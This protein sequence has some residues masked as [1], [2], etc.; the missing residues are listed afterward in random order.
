ME[1]GGMAAGGNPWGAIASTVGGVVGAFNDAAAARRRNGIL[2]SGSRQQNRAGM[3]SAGTLAEFIAKLRGTMVNP[4]TEAAAF[5]TAMGAPGI[6]G[7]STASARF[8]AGA[9][10]ANAGAQGYGR[11]V[12]GNLARVRAP[13]LQ[14]E[15]EAR[16]MMDAG[17]ALRPIQMR[18]QDDEF[19]TNLRAGMV[20]PNPWVGLGSSL[21]QQ[22]GSYASSQGY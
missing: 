15:N 11:Q 13:A 1:P 17:N 18:A 19:L 12:A 2:A 16:L 8:R 5:T 22:G 10:S 20:K 6:A 21:L 14:R 3:E 7:P 9:T 4:N